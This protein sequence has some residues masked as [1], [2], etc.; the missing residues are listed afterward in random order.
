MFAKIL[1][2]LDGS[3]LAER[4]LKPAL[5]IARAAAGEITLLTVPVYRQVLVPGPTG[6]GL[7]IPDQMLDMQYE[8]AS[9]YL[10]TIQGSLDQSLVRSAQIVRGDVAGA[11]V[12]FAAEQ[13]VE[14]IVMTTHGYSGFTR[15]MLGSIT[16]RVLRK[17]PCPVMVVRCA[18]FPKHIVIT[19][20]GSELAEQALEPGLA[21]ARAFGARVTLFRVEPDDDLGSLELSLLY[22]A[23]TD[24]G[25]ELNR[26]CDER[27]EYYLECLAEKH[28]S[29]DLQIETL[30]VKGE[31]AREILQFTESGQVDLLAM[32][33]HGH[34][35]L[36]R[37]VYGSITGK[38]L[39]NS[40]CAMLI[41]RPPEERL[42]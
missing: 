6:Y 11:I 21:L 17:A 27:L 18:D 5:E 3:E 1:V 29:A 10:T 24:L 14:L 37:W 7:V 12:D 22:A 2:P 36:R 23:G 19:L 9:Q 20:D 28:R 15:W 34:T 16:E 32:A 35:G 30:V 33:T 8:E 42:S 25:R 13:G 31:P 40:A 26:E 4:A 38:C 41:V 39:H